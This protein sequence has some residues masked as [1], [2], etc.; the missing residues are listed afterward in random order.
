MAR[1]ESG[2]T[3]RLQAAALELYAAR[4]F[5]GVTVAEI[6]ERAGLTERTFFRHFADKREVLFHGQKEFEAVFLDGIAQ[7]A[8]AHPM[9]MITA[10]LDAAARLFPEQRRPWSRRRQQVILDNPAFME[11][12]LLKLSGLALTMTQVLVERGIDPITAAL[13]G[14]SGVTVFRTAF[15]AWVADGEQR[16][17]AELQTVVLDRLHEMLAV[18]TESAT[19]ASATRSPSPRV[20]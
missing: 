15:T 10:A 8:D 5:D 2:A 19:P 3:E 7:A 13:A 12:E 14:E 6:A 17:F 11:R 4:G 1:W 9:A 20:R 16:T 18:S